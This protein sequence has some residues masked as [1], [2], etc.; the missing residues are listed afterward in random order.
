MQ[1]LM[2]SVWGGAWFYISNQCWGIQGLGCATLHLLSEPLILT[3]SSSKDAEWESISIAVTSPF[4]TRFLLS[5]LNAYSWISDLN[6][7]VIPTE[8]SKSSPHQG[9]PGLC[10]LPLSRIPCL[11]A[12]EWRPSF[13]VQLLLASLRPSL[14]RPE[15]VLW[16]SLTPSY[17]SWNSL[18]S[19]LFPGPFQASPSALQPFSLYLPT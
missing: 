12:G 11:W 4:R 5:V 2:Q 18:G 14:L 1:I 15:P 16:W 19:S 3:A 9:L 10:Q 17:S 6:F 7:K 8:F 13:R